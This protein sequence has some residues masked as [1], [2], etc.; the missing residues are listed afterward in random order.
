M[1]DSKQEASEYLINFLGQY[2]AFMEKQLQAVRQ[3]MVDTVAEVMEGVNQISE[4]TESKRVQAEQTLEQTYIEPD[5]ETQ[6]LVDDLQKMVSDLFDEAQQSFQ[7]GKSLDALKS[8][9]PEILLQNRINRFGGKFMAD[10]DGLSQLDDSL[11]TLLLGIMGALSSEDVI[12]QRMDHI[13][14]SL[15]MLQ[16]GLN[17]ILIDYA[18]R[19]TP[20]ELSKVTQ[21]IKSYTFR[22]Y[23]SEDEKREFYEFFP[24]AKSS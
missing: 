17:Y 1:A 15:K 12:A 5:A 18:N 2:T 9:E 3:T 23:T 21:D 10:M 13:I 22:Q 20:T 6:V 8:M 7:Q 14:M 24:E 16:T 4:T 19:C 11:K